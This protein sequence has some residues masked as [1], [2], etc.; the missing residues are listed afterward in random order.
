MAVL[1]F[2]VLALIITF[3]KGV[4]CEY[5][6]NKNTSYIKMQYQNSII[7]ILREVYAEVVT[8]TNMTVGHTLV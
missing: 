6:T 1:Q 8:C 5:L 3:T 2:T 7:L 4:P